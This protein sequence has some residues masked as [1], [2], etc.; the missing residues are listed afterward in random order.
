MHITFFVGNGFDISCGLQ[1]SYSSFYKWYCEVKSE[2][3]HIDEFKNAI[4]TDIRD[5]KNNWADFEEALGKY[6]VNFTKEEAN[7]FIECYEDAHKNLMIYLANQTSRFQDDFDDETIKAFREGLKN[8][9]FELSPKERGIIEE[10]F[11][12]H[13]H[14]SITLDFVSFNYTDILD[15]MIAVEAKEPIDIWTNSN[16]GRCTYT[17]S[18]KVIHAHGQMKYHPVFGVN[19]EQQ[20]ENKSLLEVPNFANLMIKPKCVEELGEYWHDEIETRINN[21]TIICIYGM[22]MGITDTRWFSKILE[23]LRVNNSRHII[24]FYYTDHPS[25]GISNWDVFTKTS[26]I[27]LKL[28]NHSDYSSQI[29]DDIKDRIHMIE[30]TKNVLQLKLTEKKTG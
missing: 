8:F 26:E 29:T 13:H 4:K 25:D 21:S 17:I 11:K 14:E 18:S 12:S 30:N 27:R 6:T 15:K 22:S 28:L 2:K 5:G 10:V 9:Y 7:Q 23:W 16:G 3:A 1:S 24:I 19:D 20:I